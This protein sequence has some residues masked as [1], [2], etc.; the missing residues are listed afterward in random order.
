[1]ETITRR[2]ERAEDGN[3]IFREAVSGTFSNGERVEEK[4]KAERETIDNLL[5]K[6]NTMEKRNKEINKVDEGTQGRAQES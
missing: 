6:M 3:D 1:M 5:G 4:V 2:M